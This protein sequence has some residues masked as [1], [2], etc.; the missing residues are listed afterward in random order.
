MWSNFPSLH[1]G[2]GENVNSFWLKATLCNFPW[3]GIYNTLDTLF[4]LLLKRQDR[5][6]SSVYENHGFLSAFILA[7]CRKP[8]SALF[9]SG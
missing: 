6:A 3:Y 4:F 8:L 2:L 5:Q 9:Q 7:I 1:R